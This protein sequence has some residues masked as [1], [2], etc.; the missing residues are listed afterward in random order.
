MVVPEMPK[1]LQ[2]CESCGRTPDLAMRLEY[3]AGCPSG[4]EILHQFEIDRFSHTLV[5]CWDEDKTYSAT[6]FVGELE[7]ERLGLLW[8][9]AVHAGRAPRHTYRRTPISGL[10]FD[11]PRITRHINEET[12]DITLT[13]SW[14]TEA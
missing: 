11:L 12:G 4:H 13:C 10:T 6:C 14:E 1:E 3:L 2:K 5:H 7:P 8:L 9:D